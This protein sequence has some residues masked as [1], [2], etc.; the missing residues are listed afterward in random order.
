M[1]TAKGNAMKLK[2][3]PNI[4]L[5]S[6]RFSLELANENCAHWDYENGLEPSEDCCYHLIAAKRRLKKAIAK[7]A[8]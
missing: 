5:A 6:A 2:S 4:E 7:A 1:Q 8:R 3:T